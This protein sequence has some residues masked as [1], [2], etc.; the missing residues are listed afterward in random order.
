MGVPTKLSLTR[1]A[2]GDEELASI[3]TLTREDAKV[4]I[5]RAWWQDL[6]TT[7]RDP[8]DESDRHWNWREL[9]SANLNKPYFPA[10][11]VKSAD[12]AIQ[13]AAIY[14]V[15]ARSAIEPG[16]RAVF[17]D[18]LATAPWNRDWLAARPRFRGT[19]TGLLRHAIAT[20]YSLGLAGRVALFPIANVEFYVAI[21]FQ[22]TDA[23]VSDDRLYELPSS[24]AIEI[25]RQRG[26]IP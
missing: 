6:G 17:V 11:C 2:T 25:L 21:G 5:D 8:T 4:L 26:L 16:Q 20:S 7:L 22:P 24:S 1:C 10:V 23:L 14:Q 13:G 15:N 9:V 18:R 3:D 19:G 12:G